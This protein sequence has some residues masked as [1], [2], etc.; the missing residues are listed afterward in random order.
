MKKI[1]VFAVVALLVVCLFAVP[2]SA[3]ID[4]SVTYFKAGSNTYPVEE[5]TINEIKW[6]T[7]TTSLTDMEIRTSTPKDFVMGDRV[8]VSFVVLVPVDTR[9]VT[10]SLEPYTFNVPSSNMQVIGVEGEPFMQVSYTF[11]YTFTSSRSNGGF[12]WIVR[13]N[14]AW[15]SFGVKEFT[16]N[17]NSDPSVSTDIIVDNN[18]ANTDKI[19]ENDNANTDKLINGDGGSYATDDADNANNTVSDITDA[20][21]AAL[22]GKTDEEIQ[23]DIDNALDFDGD[24]LDYNSAQRVSW[25]FDGLLNCF[26]S[27][28]ET[29]LFL[30]L[31]LGLAAFLIGRRWSNG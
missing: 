14:S 11:S 31:T 13:C 20:E 30:S 24:S 4:Y 25:L 17:I 1:I 5:R 8:T 12:F 23:Q 26:G 22:G 7:S 15:S 27:D 18:N 19:I 9:V 10:L 16:F 6:Y 28:Y 3:A 29:L 2:A 21:N